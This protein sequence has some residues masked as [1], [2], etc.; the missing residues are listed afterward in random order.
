MLVAERDELKTMAEQAEE[1]A[2][3]VKSLVN[4]DDEGDQEEG[5]SSR[6]INDSKED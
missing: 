5:D 6:E 2:K 4:V 3:I 1:L